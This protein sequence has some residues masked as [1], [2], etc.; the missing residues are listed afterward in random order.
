MSRGVR[1]LEALR[2]ARDLPG[3]SVVPFA[4]LVALILRADE[5]G[6]SWPSYETIAR[7]AHVSLR[8]AKS[9]IQALKRDGHIRV[10]RRSVDGR[11]DPD[12]NLYEVVHHVHEVV[13]EVHDLVHDMHGGSAPGARQVVQEVHG[14]S[15]PRALYLRKELRNGTPHSLAPARER[16]AG[17]ARTSERV[18]DRTRDREPSREQTAPPPSDAPQADVDAWCAS[19]GIPTPAAD[20]RVAALLDHARAHARRSADWAA[21]WRS[22]LRRQAEHAPRGGSRVAPGAEPRVETADDYRARQRRA[23]AEHERLRATAAP[24]P[25]ADLMAAIGSAPPRGTRGR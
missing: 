5:H 11:R 13:Q 24:A 16:A 8:S 25:V 17:A 2:A 20:D 9:A 22:W 12:S 6:K 14:G 23:D 4:V 3:L 18:R 19:H 21:A 1:A 7:D 10:T 15:A